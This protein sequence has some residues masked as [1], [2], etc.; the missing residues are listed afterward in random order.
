MD[1]DRCLGRVCAIRRRSKSSR[2]QC[3]FIRGHK[4]KYCKHF[5][6]MPL[7][8]NNNNNNNDPITALL[9]F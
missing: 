3:G 1:L 9:L 5:L 7:Y 8:N 2:F 4:G 6:N